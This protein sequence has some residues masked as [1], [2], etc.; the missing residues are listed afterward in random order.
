MAQTTLDAKENPR[1]PIPSKSYQVYNIF[2]KQ[3]SVNSIRSTTESEASIP[4][5]VISRASAANV[6][7]ARMNDANAAFTTG[8]RWAQPLTHN[9]LNSD[10]SNTRRMRLP[11]YSASQVSNWNQSLDTDH[12]VADQET[13]TAFSTS[14]MRSGRSRGFGRGI[15]DF[16]KWSRI[17]L[18][19]TEYGN[20][21]PRI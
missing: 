3:N 5:S 14:P 19:G 18:F 10:I 16:T 4:M 12:R 21:I 7:S 9:K 6:S 8:D 15:F 1:I 20:G 2:S 17:Y 13:M 11:G